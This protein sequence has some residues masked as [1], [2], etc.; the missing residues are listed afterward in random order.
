MRNAKQARELQNEKKFPPQ[1]DS[2]PQFQ[3][4]KRKRLPLR[5]GVILNLASQFDLHLANTLF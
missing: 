5:R 4:T 1:W 2:N 3:L